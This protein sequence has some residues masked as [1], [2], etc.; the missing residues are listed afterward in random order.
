MTL[1]QLTEAATWHSA[2]PAHDA[3]SHA[4]VAKRLLQDRAAIISIAVPD[5]ADRATA[6]G[7]IARAFDSIVGTLTPPATL[8]AAGGETLRAICDTLGASVLVV[9]KRNRPRHPRVPHARRALGGDGCD[10]EIRAPSVTQDC[11]DA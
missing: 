10:L 6:A 9:E 3:V 11:W 2:L 5:G 4:G 8:F 1:R 7:Q